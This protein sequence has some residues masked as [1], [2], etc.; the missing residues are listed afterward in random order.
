[1]RKKIE[2]VV[3][4]SKRPNANAKRRPSA[5]GKTNNAKRWPNANGKSNNGRL[6]ASGGNRT[7]SGKSKTAKPTAKWKCYNS[8]FCTSKKN[9]ERR[10]GAGEKSESRVWFLRLRPA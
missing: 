7:V 1:V 10:P 8:N 6:N 3:G 2:K 9:K 4:G 5:N